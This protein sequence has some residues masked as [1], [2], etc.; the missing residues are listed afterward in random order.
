MYVLIYYIFTLF[1]SSALEKY[2]LTYRSLN[3]KTVEIH[4][5]KPSKIFVALLRECQEF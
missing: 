2:E 3:E 5:V 1:L 4:S